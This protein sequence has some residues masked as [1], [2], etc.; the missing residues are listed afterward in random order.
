MTFRFR[1]QPA[2]DV[3]LSK[4]V[5]TYFP[6]TGICSLPQRS[7]IGGSE[8]R[9]YQM[10]AT[11]IVPGSWAGT[12]W[13]EVFTGNSDRLGRYYFLTKACHCHGV[14]DWDWQLSWKLRLQPQGP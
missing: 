8:P 4:L 10:A 1:S 3:P 11:V 5:L 14:S 9:T 7:A 6:R 2:V 13:V 12:Y